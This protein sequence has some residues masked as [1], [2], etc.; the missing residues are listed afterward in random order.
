MP[1]LRLSKIAEESKVEFDKALEIAQ[2]ELPKGSLTGK[3][4]NTWVA[5]EAQ[6]DLIELLEVPELHTKKYRGGVVRLAPNP[7][8]VYAYINDLKKTI[9]CIVP[10]RFQKQMLGKKIDIEQIQDEKGS[11]FRYVKHKIYAK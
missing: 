6:E 2:Q 7:S 4:R 9:P 10:R 11:S 3:G 1:K 8:Y 5:Q